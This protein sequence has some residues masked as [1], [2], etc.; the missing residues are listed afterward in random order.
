MKTVADA[1][2]Q[3]KPLTPEAYLSL[4]RQKLPGLRA[5]QCRWKHTP[6]S[7]R[8]AILRR[9]RKILSAESDRFARAIAHENGKTPLEALT[10]EIIPT[11]D[12]VE[13]LEKEAAQILATRPLRL[14]TRQFYFK[15]KDNAIFY[16]PYGVIGILGTWNYPFFLCM[17]QVLFALIAGNAVVLKGSEFSFR[18][19][20]L[21]AELLTAAG[22]DPE[23]FHCFSAGS[24]AGEALVRLECDKYILTGARKTGK[25]VMKMLAETMTPAV[26]ELSG[27]DPYVVLSDAD[28]P[29]AVKV[30]IWA[31]YQ[32]SGQ[33]CVAPRR[34]LLLRKDRERF[35]GAFRKAAAAAQEYLS[36]QGILRSEVQAESQCRTIA[37]LKEQGARLEFG[38]ESS[39][40][41]TAYFGPRVYSGVDDRMLGDADF[42]APVIFMV[43]Y[44]DE[45][46][47]FA[48]VTSSPYALGASV[49]TRDRAKARRFAREIRAGQLWVNDAVFS[50]ALGEVAF[51]GFK[52]SGFGKTRGREGLLEMVEQKFVSFDWRSR[53]STRHLP[54]YLPMSYA[55][56]TQ[57]Q[58]MMYL[59]SWKAKFRAFWDL[60]A[61]FM[62]KR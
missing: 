11:L 55:V 52:E 30:L 29:M 61:V 21:L 9:L 53:R 60:C 15:G 31:A 48:A 34:V 1:Q 19:T 54:P 14:K 59:P 45:E 37:A 24:G 18:V 27:C 32:Y 43:E 56:M 2:I 49:W 8:I 7:E 51:G 39:C 6:M 12:A 25:A 13:F 5:A 23:L 57:I 10:Q 38:D 58:R 26:M 4:F 47:L 35:L 62:P 17:T 28:W 22:F 50:V 16:E 42:M 40:G 44:E 33:T 36:E 46:A 41:N 20:D 3:E